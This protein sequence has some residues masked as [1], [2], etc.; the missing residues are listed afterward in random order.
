MW[1]LVHL[2]LVFVWCLRWVIL[3]LSAL[4]TVACWAA[5]NIPD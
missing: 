5:V 2:I 4:F 1:H 3:G